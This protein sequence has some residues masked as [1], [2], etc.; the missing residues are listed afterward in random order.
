MT[1][2]KLIEVYHRPYF[3]ALRQFTRISMSKNQWL[4]SVKTK[5]FSG[6]FKTRFFRY[7][8]EIKEGKKTKITQAVLL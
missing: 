7:G 4:R 2:G 1:R 5:Y 8:K 6:Y 3:S